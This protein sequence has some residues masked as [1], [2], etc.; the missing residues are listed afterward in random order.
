[1][2]SVRDDKVLDSVPEKSIFMS[3][4][5]SSKRDFFCPM[6]RFPFR[7]DDSTVE[8]ASSVKMEKNH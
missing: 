3:C 5:S 1:M 8:T 2:S 7:S 6:D 4:E